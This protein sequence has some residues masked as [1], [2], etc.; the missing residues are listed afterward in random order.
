MMA[1]SARVFVLERQFHRVSVP[2]RSE[3]FGFRATDL[4]QIVRLK[5]ELLR[6]NWWSFVPQIGSW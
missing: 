6:R 2:L 3:L 5:P 4:R 1:C